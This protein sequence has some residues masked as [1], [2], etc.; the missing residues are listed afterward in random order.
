MKNKPERYEITNIDPKV[1]LSI[2]KYCLTKDI[3]A[4]TWAKNAHTALTK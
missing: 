3:T 2:K 4:A 1:K